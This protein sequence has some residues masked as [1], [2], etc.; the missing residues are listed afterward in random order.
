[1]A[2]WKKLIKSDL[3][4]SGLARGIFWFENAGGR[5]VERYFNKLVNAR[6]HR[7]TSWSNGAIT[8]TVFAQGQVDM[9]TNRKTGRPEQPI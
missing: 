3:H 6:G 9:R 7:R 8:V 2:I 5:E 4:F 1:M